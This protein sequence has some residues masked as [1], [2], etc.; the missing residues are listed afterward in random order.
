M[1]GFLS[2]HK[3]AHCLLAA[4]GIPAL[5]FLFLRQ[6]T[7]MMNWIVTYITT[8]VKR[9]LAQLCAA[10][11][12]SV[13]ELLIAA[14]VLALLVFLI[15][16]TV[17]VAKGPARRGT[18]YRTLCGV[19]FAALTIYGSVSWLYGA[20]YYADSFQALS[21][22]SP[23]SATAETLYQL[24]AYF[25]AEAAEAGALVERDENGLFAAELDTLFAQ[26]VTAYTNLESQF[27]FLEMEA[28]TPKALQLSGLMSYTRFTGFFFPFTGEANINIDA[29]V[30]MLPATILHEMAHQ[31]NVASEDEANFVAIL[32]GVTSGIDAFAYSCWLFGY[33]HL[34]NALYQENVDLWQEARA[35]LS[36]GCL[37]DLDY[38]NSYWSAYETVVSQVSEGVYDS[39]LKGY[40][41]SS[42]IKSYGAAADLLLAYFSDTDVLQLT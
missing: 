27:S 17:R 29:P 12:V 33:A 22:L 23:S 19:L 9:G 1:N 40:G 14:F 35:F 38:N 42:G 8:P 16:Q 5:A 13:A 18:L 15:R 31:R 41:E 21:G 24:T 2:V 26:S 32:A 39:F 37:A 36:D 34:S 6:Y 4:A 7:P 3:R 30:C 11:S 25:A 20:N 10:V 28:V